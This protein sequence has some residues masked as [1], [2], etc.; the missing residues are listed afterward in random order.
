VSRYDDI[1]GPNGRMPVS[2]GETSAH[3][4]YLDPPDEPQHCDCCEE[5]RARVEELTELVDWT[6]AHLGRIIVLPAVCGKVRLAMQPWSGAGVVEG[7]TMAEALEAL[8]KE[9]E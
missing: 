6:G 1:Y 5:A 9:H 4:R 3:D 7:K 2:I 8:K